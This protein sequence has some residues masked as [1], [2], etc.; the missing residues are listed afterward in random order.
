MH[1]SIPENQACLIRIRYFGDSNAKVIFAGCD[2]SAGA[3]HANTARAGPECAGRRWNRSA[4]GDNHCAPSDDDTPAATGDTS[5]QPADS[6][7][8]ASKKPAKKKMTRQQEI[9][10]SVD[11]GT[12]PAR[13]R[14]SE[15]WP[16]LF[17]QRP[18]GFKWIPAG[19]C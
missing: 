16:R 1:A 19:L 5:S 10:H 2:S 14:S 15:S 18:A 13:Y 7:K 17:G 11:T 3:F 12:V 6:K 8:S 4:C 9:D